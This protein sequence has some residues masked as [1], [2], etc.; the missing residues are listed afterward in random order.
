MR[1]LLAAPRGFC[2]GVEMAVGAL[3]SALARFGAPVY[4]YHHIV[5][6][7]GVVSDFEARG[8]VFVD[9]VDA[10]PE[11]APVVFSAHGVSPAVRAAAEA[12]GLR[13]VD[14]TCPLVAKVHAEA[15]RFARLG[16]TIVLVGHREHDETVGVVGEAPAHVVVVESPAEV[17]ALVVPDASRVAYLTQ[18]TLSLDD[19]ADVVAALRDRFPDVV[20]PPSSDVC[21]ATTNRQEA[22]RAVA[23]E[24]EVVLVLGSATSSNTLRLVETAR[25]AGRRAFR[26][27][28]AEEI[29]SEWLD[30]A[31]TVALTA[32]ASVPETVVAH[33][34]EWLAARGVT[35]VET[36]RVREESVRFRLPLPVR[37][38]SAAREAAAGESA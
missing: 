22:V 29:R 25:A 19:V 6:N 2:A 14:A 31:R 21:Y 8:V 12:R 20:G 5:H 16:Y 17:A 18:T 35:R 27:D 26:V 15:R 37:D 34:A 23:A 38:G 33:C 36:R 1:L 7:R 9:D 13:V 10:V 4:A 3:D 32:G 11:G 24:A 30:G 28:A